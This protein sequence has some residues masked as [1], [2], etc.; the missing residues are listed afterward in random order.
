[1]QYKLPQVLPVSFANNGDKATEMRA[2]VWC[3][4]H[5]VKACRD[6]LHPEMISMVH[7]LGQISATWMQVNCPVS[8]DKSSNTLVYALCILYFLLKL[9]PFPTV[10][11]DSKPLLSGCKNSRYLVKKQSPCWKLR[12]NSPGW[13]SSLGLQPHECVFKACGESHL[14]TLTCNTLLSNLGMTYK[15]SLCHS[16]K[17]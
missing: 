14:S 1:M 12:Q 16:K 10:T 4:R 6:E 17:I 13:D 5:S 9:P 7:S 15:I 11:L 2:N 8:K 3:I